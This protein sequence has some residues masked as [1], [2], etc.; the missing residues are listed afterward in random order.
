LAEFLSLDAL[1][2]KKQTGNATRHYVKINQDKIDPPSPAR[3]QV[4]F[5]ICGL[6]PGIAQP[7]KLQ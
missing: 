1:T 4:R 3:G 7:A 2:Q 6:H 5:W